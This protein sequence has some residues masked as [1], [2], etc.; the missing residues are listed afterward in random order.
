[1]GFNNL[2]LL[3]NIADPRWWLLFISI[4]LPWVV[5]WNLVAKKR[6]FEILTYG[7]LWAVMAT[8]LDLLGTTNGMW[9]YPFKLY[10]NVSVIPVLYMFLYQY[11]ER[12]KTFIL[13]SVIL[14]SLLSFV[15]EPIFLK[16]NMLNLITWSHTKSWFA[17][18]FLALITRLIITV[19]KKAQ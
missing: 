15:F 13:G 17:F 4:F 10:N 18:I 12:W 8:W 9:E 1:M 2:I 5:W 16:M 6:L 3:N 19:L 7:L 11:G 14:S